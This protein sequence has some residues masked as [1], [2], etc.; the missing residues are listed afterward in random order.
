[1]IGAR[2]VAAALV[3][4]LAAC[5]AGPPAAHTKRP[6]VIVVM[7]DDQGYGDFC[8]HGN[9]VLATPRLDAF[10]RQCPQVGRFYVSPVCSPT[11]AS[12]MTGRYNY[13]TRVV[14]T[15]IGR[16]MMEP[17]E[18]T[19]AEELRRA[20]YRTGI[21]GK[22]HLG[23]CYP[24]RPQDQGFDEVL[25]HRGGG[26]GQPSEPLENGR[27]YTD[28][29]LF[30]NGEQVETE[31]YCT[32]VYFDAAMRFVDACQQEQQP[33]FAYI[34]TNAPHDPLHDV[35]PDLY[36][37]YRATDLGPVLAGAEADKV[38]RVY[39]MVADIDRQFGR[40]LDHLAA[41][42]LERDTI[43]VFLTDNGPTP[44][45][46]VNGLRGHKTSV[47]EGGVR[48]PL[49]V[50]WPARLSP[51]TR[52]DRITAH[53]DLLPTIC[54]AVGV[55]PSAELDGRSLWPDLCGAK[56]AEQPARRLFL[57]T[58]RGAAP[59]AQHHI[60]VVG[61]RWK[62]VRHSGFGRERPAPDAPFELFDLT[63][64]PGEANDL[65]ARHPDVVAELRREYDAWF[66]DVSGER[67]HNYAPPRIRVGTPHEP[68]TVLTRQDWIPADGVGW[69]HEGVWKLHVDAERTFDV[70]LVFRDERAVETASFATGLAAPHVEHL[71]LEGA[72]VTY[73][74]VPFA[75]GPVDLRVVCEAGDGPFAP[76]QVELRAR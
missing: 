43:V 1:M 54:D 8:A 62:L 32:G 42:D 37:D 35:P 16:S 48:S 29:I 70:T 19:I 64:D 25:V 31:G 6:N 49:W 38:A 21:F 55:A 17:A 47:Y 22:W 24:M 44:G 58:H 60:A 67:E 50:R 73:G 4:A 63:V 5:S 23:D 59:H 30:H 51:H 12:L 9:P 75:A 52:V 68:V 72:R 7:T 11:R 14:D 71:V 3:A 40:L 57:Q 34:A 13:R 28:A 76:Y 15:W 56:T 10:A 61:Q 2:S 66:A 18:R 65:A 45:R 20:G 27:R 53:I 33:F 41:Q 74:P 36:E 69:G 26:L 39:A 46:Y